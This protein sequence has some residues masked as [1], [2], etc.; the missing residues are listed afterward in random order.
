ALEDLGDE[1]AHEIRVEERAPRFGAR[2][3]GRITARRNLE[4]AELYLIRRGG[5]QRF[6]DAFLFDEPA[7]QP[8]LAAV[9]ARLA[10][11]VV[12]DGHEAGLD[13]AERAVRELP[14][15]D[16][17]VVDV[18]AHH[19]AAGAHHPLR[20]EVAHRAD[21]LR[22]IRADEQVRDVDDRRAVA[23]ERRHLEHRLIRLV[24]DLAQRRRRIEPLRIL[25][26]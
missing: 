18:H 25:L 19:A 16:V 1:A 23:L 17:A 26:V 15:E 24:I 2:A 11:R 8:P 22:E 10:A 5:P 21:D 6:G 20:D 7:D 9:D 12:A 3:A 13:R 4:L 14:E